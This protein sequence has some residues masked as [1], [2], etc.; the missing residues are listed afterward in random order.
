[1]GIKRSIYYYQK[2]VNM[3]KIQK[4]ILLK[5]KIQKIA[6]EHPYYGYRRITAQLHRDNIKVNH[7]RVIRIMRQLGTQG[8]IKR[9]YTLVRL[10]D[11][12]NKKLQDIGNTF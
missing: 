6:Y 11:M 5:E 4:E 7:K 3:A 9:R 10:Q 12:S 8:R 2:K 1:M